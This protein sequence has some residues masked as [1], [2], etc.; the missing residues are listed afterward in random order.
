MD[1]LGTAGVTSGGMTPAGTHR[2]VAPSG[3]LFLAL[4]A[5]QASLLVLSPIITEVGAEFGV[6]SA[7]VAQLRSV[8]GITAG[9][10]A[11]LLATKARRFP[12]TRLLGI[13]LGLLAAGSL[14]SAL[15]PVFGFLL[16]AQVVIGA[17]LA[18]VLSGGLAASEAW[19]KDG[20][21]A[22]LLSWAL[23]GQPVAWIVGQPIVG[24]VAAVDWRWAWVAVPF[25]FSLLALGAVALR[26]REAEDGVLECDP[27]GLWRLP[28]VP[29]WALGELAAFSAWAGTLVYAGAFFI[30][31]YGVSVTAT[32][33]ILGLV[34]A[35]YLPGNFAARRFIGTWPVRIVAG[36]AFAS[37]VAVA[38]FGAFTTA[39]AVSVAILAIL[40]FFA[41]GRTIAGAALGLRRAQGRRLAAMSVRTATLQLGY[42][43]GAALGGL[44]LP[45]W[46]YT[47][48]GL[49]Y[50]VLF[51][52]AGGVHVGA[53][54]G[55]AAHNGV[56]L[57]RTGS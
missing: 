13:G 25:G 40:A 30:E 35:A 48:V 24:W 36:S 39:T 57:R 29:I 42:L 18:L 6:T 5:A 34:A 22:R 54:V 47:G 33:L 49:T 17:G 51:L 4:F 2:G 7:T 31:T 44:V 38:L 8:S 43:V 12:L 41:G 26:D 52:V 27:A 50:A 53:R 45:V 3:V 1:R 56:A 15:A 16:A 23:V 10:G 19:A 14:A 11:V 28:G 9:L 46:G 21:G 37:A 20:E 32:G 55:A